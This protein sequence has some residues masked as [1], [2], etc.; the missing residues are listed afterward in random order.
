M[1]YGAYGIAKNNKMSE[2]SNIYV[3]FNKTDLYSSLDAKMSVKIKSESYRE[4]KMVELWSM[5]EKTKSKNQSDHQ[6]QQL[7]HQ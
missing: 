5:A 1:G 4:V 3:F 7:L 6:Y 2:V